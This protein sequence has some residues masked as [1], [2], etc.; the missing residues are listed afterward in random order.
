MVLVVTVSEVIIAV[1]IVEVPVTFSEVVVIEVVPNPE[2]S[3]R[4]K[5]V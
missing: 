5:C 2:Q 3:I 4:L 1:P